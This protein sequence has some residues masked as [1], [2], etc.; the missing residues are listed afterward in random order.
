MERHDREPGIA[1]GLTLTILTILTILLMSLVYLKPM[2]SDNSDPVLYQFKLT[3]A[4]RTRF[5]QAALTAGVSLQDWVLA[6]LREAA[7]ESPTVIES[8]PPPQQPML[9]TR[10][11]D[12]TAVYPKEEEPDDDLSFLMPAAKA[13]PRMVPRAQLMAE[14]AKGK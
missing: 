14:L 5:K 1:S 6:R 9:I 12:G 13:T 8:A 4:D 10:L 2:T 7:A 3:R 11:L